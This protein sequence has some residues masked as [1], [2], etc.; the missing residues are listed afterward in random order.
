MFRV[1]PDQLRISG[2]W[3]R[4]GNCDE[5]FDANARLQPMSEPVAPVAPTAP[6]PVVPSAQPRKAPEPEPEPE[7]EPDFGPDTLIA[8]ELH[9]Q[10]DPILHLR[11]REHVHAQSMPEAVA[12]ELDVSALGDVVPRS[13][14]ADD[15][16]RFVQA[17]PARAD[18][19]A[20]A[21]LSFLR[22]PKKRGF[23]ARAAGRRLA[24]LACVAGVLLLGLQMVVQERDRIVAEQ[25]AATIALR[26]LCDVLGC[27]LAP[28]RQI[29]SL[30][31]DSSAFVK[32]RA[33]TYRLSATLR[34]SGTLAVAVPALEL[35]LTDGQDQPVVRKVL[36]APE[37]AGAQT[38]IAAGG[39]LTVNLPLAVQGSAE[40]VSFAGYRLLAFYP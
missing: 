2:G 16:P 13:A 25:P 36:L 15:T 34:N 35:T 33:D 9:P 29:E 7:P 19:A 38:S 31:I 5:V 39:E 22:K 6:A 10:D 28:W 17:A 3:V 20:M 14:A 11:P 32:M 18:A 12:Q 4:C 24:A 23:W 37:L 21:E 27:K 1:V 26:A 40:N 30:L 8:P